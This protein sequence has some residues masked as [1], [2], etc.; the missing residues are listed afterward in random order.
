V[1][2]SFYILYNSFTPITGSPV[3]QSRKPPKR[4]LSTAELVAIIS[5]VARDPGM[6]S[7]RLRHWTREGLLDPIGGRHPGSG[8][9]RRYSEETASRAAVLSRLADMGFRVTALEKSMHDIVKRIDFVRER[10][11]PGD[12]A[13]LGIAFG[14]AAAVGAPLEVRVYSHYGSVKTPAQVLPPAGYPD[15]TII[16]LGQIFQAVVAASLQAS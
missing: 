13:Y 6:I 14:R 10:W 3:S 1:S 15:F 12:S 11:K 16:D 2:R 5:E 9:H 4:S 8:V 7:E